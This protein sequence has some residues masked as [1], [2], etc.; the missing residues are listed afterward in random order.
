MKHYL[1]YLPTILIP[2]ALSIP[3]QANALQIVYPKTETITISADSTFF[4]WQP[5][6]VFLPGE[7]QG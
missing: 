5:T 2:F 4:I 7:S 6:P 1:K 3:L